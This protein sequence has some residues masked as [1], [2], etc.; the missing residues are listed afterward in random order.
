MPNW[1]YSYAFALYRKSLYVGDEYEDESQEK[2]GNINDDGEDVEHATDNEIAKEKSISQQADDALDAALCRF[3]FIPRLLLEKNN[4]NVTTARSFQ[5]DWPEVIGPL[6]KI[7]YACNT[8][9]VEKIASIF[10]ERSYKLW[11]GEDIQKWLYQ[12]CQRVVKIRSLVED[13]KLSGEG[14]VG[15]GEAAQATTSLSSD[16]YSPSPS[17]DRY[18]KVDPMDYHDSFRRI[19][20]DVN[21]LD[22]GVRDAALNYTPN[23][24]RFL[25]MNHMRQGGR[26]GNNEGGIDL[27]TIARRQQEMMATLLGAGRDGMAVIDP[28]L[29]LAEVFWRSMM[30][31]ARVEGVPPAPPP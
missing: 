12:G 27:E 9:S 4:V 7:N 15:E 23:R 17:L 29:P 5:T 22:P 21:P 6:E 25:R 19:P 30:P 26:G 31:W 13:A 18:L 24:R 28:D 16:P 8:T 11:S 2:N 3:P 10:V 1:S 20:V 14:G